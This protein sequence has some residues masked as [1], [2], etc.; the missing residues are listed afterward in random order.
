MTKPIYTVYKITN[1]IND[2]IYIGVHTTLNPN[3]NYMG[4]GTLIKK[5][6][7]KYGIVNFTKS[8][9]FEY[10]NSNDAYLKESQI[11]N[12]S[13]VKRIDT[14]NLTNGGLGGRTFSKSHKKN[15][16]NSLIGIKRP[17]TKEHQDKITKSITGQKRNQKTR[18]KVSKSKTGNLNP[19]FNGYYITPIGRFDS[20]TKASE[21]L[22]LSKPT[23]RSWCKT[24]TKTINIH[25]IKQSKYLK[26][27]KESPMG[28]TF[29]EIGFDFEPL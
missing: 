27:L 22:Y 11:V 24:A 2:K 25:S 7:A 8:I 1:T 4:S 16:S 9:L 20:L 13:F 18:D 29:R 19:K 23:I 6:I 12:N 15:L 14:Y 17:R 26:S 21:I 10:D 28:K 5:A 3:D